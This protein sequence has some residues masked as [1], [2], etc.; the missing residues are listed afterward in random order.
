M[1]PSSLP[2]PLSHLQGLSLDNADGLSSLVRQLAELSGLDF[3]SE[4][5][6]TSATKLIVETWA[7]PASTLSND[8]LIAWIR[9]AE[10]RPAKHVDT[11]ASGFFHISRLEA[12]NP[13]ETKQFPKVGLRPGDSVRCRLDIEGEPNKSRHKCFAQGEVADQLDEWPEGVLLSGTLVC[14]GQMKEFTND[15]AMDFDEDRGVEYPV[16][17]LIKSVKRA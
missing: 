2:T 3:P 11:E 13:Q 8:N 15:F 7:P 4:F 12:T 1:K 5:D 16:A 6:F 17:W 9:R 14:I 10:R